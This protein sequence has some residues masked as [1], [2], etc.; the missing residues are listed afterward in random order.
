[1]KLGPKNTTAF[2]MTTLKLAKFLL[3]EL[4]LL[5]PL[6]RNPYKLERITMKKSLLQIAA[7]VIP[8]LVTT[9]S[10]AKLPAPSDEAKA[11]AAEASAKTAWSGKVEGFLLCKAQDKVAAKYKSIKVADKDA[12][13]VPKPG[14]KDVN[15]PAA[16]GAC[17][18]P[19]P[20]VYTP[21]ASPAVAATPAPA[22]VT[23]AAAVPA[24]KS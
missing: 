18:D 15:P 24:K 22:A 1:M 19:G 20:F 2:G 11:K 17:T 7:F 13:P 3:N 12:K 4:C 5:R 14:P 9:V 6:L 23:P 21:A 16:A 8:L 10:L